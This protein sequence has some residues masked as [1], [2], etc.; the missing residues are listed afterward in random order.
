MIR[1]MACGDIEVVCSALRNLKYESPYFE[2]Y[3]E[4]AEHVHKTLPGML[5]SAGTVALIDDQYRGFM[6]G[7]VGCNWYSPVVEANEALLYV[8]E[9]HRGGRTAVALIRAF[10]QEAKRYGAVCVNAGASLGIREDSVIQLYLRLGYMRKG[11]GV[12]KRIEHV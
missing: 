8:F 6:L 12:T 10:E 2:E 5:N 4:D 7:F 3:P 1:H 11:H 9:E